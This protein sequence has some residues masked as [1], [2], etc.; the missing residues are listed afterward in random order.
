[1]KPESDVREEEEEEE[2]GWRETELHA[3]PETTLTQR[4]W[5]FPHSKGRGDL[6]LESRQRRKQE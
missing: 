4:R 1:M 2:E 6:D 3:L 5:S